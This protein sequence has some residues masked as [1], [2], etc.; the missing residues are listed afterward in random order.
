[1][2]YI[3]RNLKKKK[4]PEIIKEMVSERTET[5]IMRNMGLV[6]KIALHF[7]FTPFLSH[8]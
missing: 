2:L 8:T 3:H 6:P 5:H 1:M 4:K 7:E